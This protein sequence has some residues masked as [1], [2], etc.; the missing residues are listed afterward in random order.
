MTAIDDT[1][2]MHRLA[3]LAALWSAD[4]RLRLVRD[5]ACVTVETH[6]RTLAGCEA[7]TVS[8]AVTGCLAQMEALDAQEVAS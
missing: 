2:P 4:V 6:R 5:R 8:E 7:D 3:R 1:N